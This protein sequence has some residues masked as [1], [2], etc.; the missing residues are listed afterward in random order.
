MGAFTFGVIAAATGFAFIAGFAGLTFVYSLYLQQERGLSPLA[1]GLTF[2]PMTV[3][4]GFVSV[5]AH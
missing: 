1:I 5:P 2:L 3:L 4:S